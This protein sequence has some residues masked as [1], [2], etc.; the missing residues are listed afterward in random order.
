MTLLY[1]KATYAGTRSEIAQALREVADDL[2]MDSDGDS[3]TGGATYCGPGACG[4][5][6]LAPLTL[7]S[8]VSP[9]VRHRIEEDQSCP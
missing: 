6:E 7:E 1:L 5:W 2:D 3:D 4:D 8:L 9:S